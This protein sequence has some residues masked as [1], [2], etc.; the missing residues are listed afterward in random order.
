MRSLHSLMGAG[1]IIAAALTLSACAVETGSEESAGAPLSTESHA[2]GSNPL[3]DGTMIK[4]MVPHGGAAGTT[5]TDLAINGGKYFLLRSDGYIERWANL[6]SPVYESV[7]AANV[8]GAIKNVPLASG[9]AWGVIG[10]IPAT[11]KLVK[12]IQLGAGTNFADWPADASWISQIAGV[13][14]SQPG[15]GALGLRAYIVRSNNGGPGLVQTGEYFPTTGMS[16]GSTV[17]YG[18]YST[19][20]ALIG[21]KAYTVVNYLTGP[22]KAYTMPGLVSTGEGLSPYTDHAYYNRDRSF[23][24]RFAPKGM[25]YNS[26]DSNFY[27]IDDS[28]TGGVATQVIAKLPKT[29]LRSPLP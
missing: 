12:N 28:V 6:A 27:G 5:F 16:W 20:L 26:A 14:I 2:L 10:T 24:D 4:T 19:G 7:Y 18:P 8:Y 29:A 21:T 22:F 23:W 11:R 17:D 25:D 3:Q 13:V 1:M 9:P 15:T